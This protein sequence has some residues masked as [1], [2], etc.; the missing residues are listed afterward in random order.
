MYALIFFALLI[1]LFLVYCVR[2]PLTPQ[3]NVT[4]TGMRKISANGKSFLQGANDSVATS[5]EHPVFPAKFSY[6]YWLDTTEVTQKEYA[7]ITGKGSVPDTG[8][9]GAGDRYPVYDVSWFDAAMFCNVKSKKES[10]DTVYSYYGAPQVQNGSVY[11]LAGMQIHYDRNGYRLPTESEWEFAARDGTSGIP[12]PEL[13]DSATAGSYAWYSANSLGKT[14]PVAGRLPNAFGLYD[15]AGNVYEWTGDWKG[16]YSGSGVVNSIGSPMPDNDVERVIKGGSFENG[17]IS[18][19]PS[20]RGATYP[21][22]QSTVAEYIGFRCARGIIPGPAFINADTSGTSTNPSTLTVISTKSFIGTSNAR[23]VFVNVT[24]NVRTLCY[25]DFSKPYPVIQEV[26]DFQTVYAPTISPNG[27][28][29]AFCTRNALGSTGQSSVYVRTLDALSLPPVKLASNSAFVPRW[30]VDLSSKDTF[31]IYTNSAVDNTSALWPGTQTLTV[32]MEGPNPVGDY[33]ALLANGSYHDGRSHNGQYIV[34]S[35][36][37][38]I[39]HDFLG[40]KDVQLFTY[41]NNGKSADGSTQVCNASI[42]PDSS[43]GDRCLFEDFGAS[44]GS[45]LVGNPYGVHQYLFMA[46]FSGIVDAWYKCPD[47]ESAWDFPKWSN[48]GQFAIACGTNASDEPH[49]VYLVD[50]TSSVYEKIAEGQDLENPFLWINSFDSLGLGSL[51]LDS[52]GNYNDPPLVSNLADFTKRMLGFWRVHE[53]MGIVFTGSS[54]TAYGVNPDFFTGQQVYNMAFSGAP[55]GVTLSIINN[56]LLNRCPAIKLIGCDIIPGCMHWPDYYGDWINLA[57]NLG[58]N[59]DK[60]HQFWKAGLPANFEKFVALVPFPDLPNLDTL[61]LENVICINW[62]GPKP[63]VPVPETWDTSDALYKVNFQKIKSLAQVLAGR[64]IH[65]LLYITPE[66]PYYRS[67]DFYGRSGPTRTVGEE[68]V[69]QLKALQDS[70]PGYFHFYDANLEGNH[71]YA[72]SEAADF[73]HLCYVGATKL[74]RRLD[75]LVHAIL[76]PLGPP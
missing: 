10:L 13:E 66:S 16:P 50:L 65:F 6:D 75:S 18:L 17:L 46:E 45:T 38:L 51:N 33:Q 57:H 48:M 47:G 11:N 42:S 71:D 43:H 3:E 74:S 27:K 72:D 23:V 62:G 24:G 40:Q 14:Q 28:Y 2:K 31:L 25:V 70:V 69:S 15:M 73:D 20:R 55:M 56:Y 37:Q 68:I 22:S 5:N 9:F 19:R 41:P 64:N 49:S 35:Y 21:T 61:G 34:T 36:R 59:Y 54:H 30:W 76:N 32:K 53:N 52:L 8:G 39:M 26:K 67:T 7:D 4:I 1:C 63:D 12:F 44:T 58:Y 60:N 29:V